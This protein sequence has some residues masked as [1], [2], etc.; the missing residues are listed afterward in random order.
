MLGK[1]KLY[2]W[3]R[4]WT[5][6]SDNQNETYSFDYPQSY[7]KY[8]FQLQDLRDKRC[9]ILLGDAALGKSTC[10]QQEEESL[11]KDN[12]PVL[13]INLK[14]ISGEEWLNKQF[15]ELKKL[16]TKYSKVFFLVDS[17]DEGQIAFNNLVNCFIERLK[18]LD[19]EKIYLRI[20]CRTVVFPQYLLEELRKISFSVNEKHPDSEPNNTLITKTITLKKTDKHILL[21]VHTYRL[22]PL[23]KNDINL[24]LD[25]N[26]INIEEFYNEIQI[27]EELK[28]PITALY[29]I[30]EYPQIC[31]L[32]QY[33]IYENIC[34]RLCSEYNG[35][36]NRQVLDSKERLEISSII[37]TLMLF[38]NKY[39]ISYD[40]RVSQFDNENILYLQKYFNDLKNVFNILKF[41]IPSS[42]INEVLN[43][44]L[45]T[46]NYNQITC[47]QKTYLEFLAAKFI[48]D[49]NLYS[50]FKN[51]IFDE[52]NKV[53]PF[54]INTVCWLAEKNEDVFNEIIKKDPDILLTS[55]V[56]FSSQE[57]NKKLLQKVYELAENEIYGLNSFE[58]IFRKLNVSKQYIINFIEPFISSC[59][60]FIVY[61]SI[62][63]LDVNEV[64]DFNKEI[65]NIA[66]SSNYS[67]NCRINA[68]Y[69][70]KQNAQ[71]QFI[72]IT[73]YINN[74]IVVDKE[75]S[76]RYAY[77][78]INLFLPDNLSEENFLKLIS[79]DLHDSF[80]YHIEPEIIIQ[81]NKF[82]KILIN[83][84]I[85][86]FLEDKH[87]DT[88][89][90]SKLLEP[91]VE[92]L[93]LDDINY[94][95][96]LLYKVINCCY[97]HSVRNI[98]CNK[99]KTLDTKRKHKFFDYYFNKILSKNTDELYIGYY[100]FFFN[101]KDKVFLLKQFFKA[102]NKN[103]K[104]FIL[105]LLV[106]TSILSSVFYSGQYLKRLWKDI[107]T[108]VK[109]R[110]LTYYEYTLHDITD[111]IG[112]IIKSLRQNYY[113]L[114]HLIRKERPIDCLKKILNK[115]NYICS[116]WHNAIYYLSYIKNNE[117]AAFSLCPL[118]IEYTEEYHL[119]TKNEKDKL[120]NLAESYIQNNIYEKTLINNRLTTNSFKP[121][122][123]MLIAP[124]IYMVY[125]T[126]KSFLNN[127]I[128]KSDLL[129][130]SLPYLLNYPN[131][132]NFYDE[133]KKCQKELLLYL[134]ETSKEKFIVEISNIIDIKSSVTND[135]VYLEFL[136]DLS[137]IYDESFNKMLF[138]KLEDL[139]KNNI[140]TNAQQYM[141]KHIAEYL[142]VRNYENSFDLFKNIFTDELKPTYI[143]ALTIKFL[144]HY[145]KSSFHL[146]KPL[147]ETNSDIAKEYIN[148][149]ARGTFGVEYRTNLNE[150]QLNL[151]S[152][153]LA[154]LFIILENYYPCKEDTFPNGV[155]TDRDE[156]SDFRRHVINKCINEGDLIFFNYLMTN[157]NLD[158]KDFWIT[159]AKRYYTEKQY[160]YVNIEDLI[161]LILNAECRI[162]FDNKHLFDIVV[163]TLQ[164]L[165]IEIREHAAYLRVWN[166]CDNNICYPKKETSLTD[167]LKRL[168]L[169]KLNN[170]IINREVEIQ[171]KIAGSGSQMTDLLVECNTFNKNKASVVIEVKGCW[172]P[173]LKDSMKTQ[174]LNKYLCDDNS[175]KYGIYLIGWYWCNKW[176]S[177]KKKD[178][179]KHIKVENQFSQTDINDTIN[180]FGNQAKLLSNQNKRIVSVV[181]DFSIPD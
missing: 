17:F 28:T 92:K 132:N 153:E 94:F 110:K 47:I 18:Q 158:V 112:T 149:I 155:V 27:S 29:I 25:E 180:Y 3:K 118:N 31:N 60:S 79:Q 129:K 5:L 100:R 1:N 156:I 70:L 101:Y 121:F 111:K 130:R 87:D 96:N 46:G 95:S 50:S 171:P 123:D 65:F 172:N 150:V 45:F 26:N 2:N 139:S 49:N 40:K 97:L 73:D 99:V 35:Q 90:I 22:Q 14:N 137:E 41:S 56:S 159:R 169:N 107:L 51:L 32:S 138:E 108:V 126:D 76:S 173:D 141:F 38:S 165:K 106:N 72:K 37:F 175:Y 6:C 179:L 134:F 13:F 176:S 124:A 84:L 16:T 30:N 44:G 127:L 36:V 152:I 12:L 163:E 135:E 59:N 161:C 11:K 54:F 154:Q 77:T 57:K 53:L 102:K 147:L 62:T 98:L 145:K 166:E 61:L 24:V 83:K 177:E 119:L 48:Y 157:S 128:L 174:L 58:R 67:F 19:I 109:N 66:I 71:E 148:L 104:N 164:K 116:D 181:I 80:Y 144:G 21:D 115:S 143:R 120:L 64:T 75:E 114:N 178:K 125:K 105:S 89:F 34:L 52:Y 42:N 88:V 122:Y 9:L 82:H 146:Y 170:I 8:N 151:N 39:I 69:F 10:L 20:T 7:T 160:H 74:F 117:N 168:L 131:D 33:E 63:L 55:F 103:F 140:F 4:Y 85:E 167:E 43:T 23:N 142:T 133:L 81:S 136:G 162:I 78:L 113:S 86:P 15:L 93:I 68:L 91:L